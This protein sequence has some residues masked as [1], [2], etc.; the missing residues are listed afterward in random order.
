MTD[1][2]QLQQ[3]AAAYIADPHGPTPWS[4][5]AERIRG[6]I[7]RFGVVNVDDF[8]TL[9]RILAAVAL[10]EPVAAAAA[11]AARAAALSTDERR[12][13]LAR[14]AHAAAARVAALET[15]ARNADAAAAAARRSAAATVA[16]LADAMNAAPP[17]E[18]GEAIG[19]AAAAVSLEPCHRC[20]TWAPYVELANAEPGNPDGPQ[21]CSG[22]ES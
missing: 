7:D 20:G 14:D 8:P 10:A 18:I 6:R 5:D 12:R 2:P 21:L 13:A 11:D 1:S 22:C 3:L 9:R 16:D 15:T 19:R 4:V 17:E